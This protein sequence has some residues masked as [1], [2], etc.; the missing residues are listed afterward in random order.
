MRAFSARSCAAVFVVLMTLTACVSDT[1]YRSE[2]STWYKL[3]ATESDRAFAMLDCQS[4]WTPAVDALRG[5][6]RLRNYHDRETFRTC[7]EAAGWQRA[8]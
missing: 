7:M 6:V 5:T 3:D 2:D 8:D 1:P 4:G